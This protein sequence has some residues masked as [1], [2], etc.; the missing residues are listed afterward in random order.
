MKV[1]KEKVSDCLCEWFGVFGFF[2]GCC[3]GVV[4]V[5]LVTISLSNTLSCSSLGKKDHHGSME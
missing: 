3:F 4:S 5:V 2:N 1:S